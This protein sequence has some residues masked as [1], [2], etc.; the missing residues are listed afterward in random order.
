MKEYAFAILGGM[1]FFEYYRLYQMNQHLRLTNQ[2]LESKIGALHIKFVNV[3]N[4]KIQ[5]EVEYN[6]HRCSIG[7]QAY[8]N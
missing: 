3:V 1:V 7:M 6:Q 4:D 5:K 8:S 2:N